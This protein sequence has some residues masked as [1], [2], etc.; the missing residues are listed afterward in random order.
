MMTVGKGK[1]WRL[2]LL[3]GHSAALVLL[4]AF[5]LLGSVLGCVGAGLFRDEDGTV[6][7]GLA[8]ALSFLSRP[9]LLDCI[10]CAGLFCLIAFALG[11][12]AVGTVG[13]P[14]LFACRGFL[15][16]YAVGVFYRLWGFSGLSVA[17]VLFALPALFW[18]PALFALGAQGLPASW[19]LARRRAGKGSAASIRFRSF[20]PRCSVCALL[21]FLCSCVEFFC[22]P[23]LMRM[24]NG[25]FA[26]F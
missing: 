20:W 4:C 13:L 22:V 11:F 10:R 7:Q 17:L 1:K 16:C 23:A 9:Q 8:A 2:D 26:L 5:F 19:S 14:V 18:L 6:R 3:S 21:I 25:A 15:F 12:S 24:I